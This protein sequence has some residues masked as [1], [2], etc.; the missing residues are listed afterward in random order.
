[1]FKFDN[2]DKTLSVLRI[3]VWNCFKF[4]DNIRLPI[5]NDRWFNDDTYAHFTLAFWLQEYIT[6]CKFDANNFK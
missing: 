2:R 5:N 4:V 3:S 6:G 1:M